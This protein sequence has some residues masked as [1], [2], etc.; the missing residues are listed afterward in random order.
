MEAG[1]LLL[2]IAYFQVA[3]GR[4]F[5]LANTKEQFLTESLSYNHRRFVVV[6]FILEFLGYTTGS[7]AGCWSVENNPENFT[8]F[9]FD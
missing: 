9:I 2:K 8:G 1:D 5:I 7:R 3:G 6:Q 4:C